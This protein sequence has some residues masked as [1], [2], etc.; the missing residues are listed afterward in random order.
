LGFPDHETYLVEKIVYVLD[1]VNPDD[2]LSVFKIAVFCK[3]IS[4][5]GLDL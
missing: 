4:S 2:L 3:S 1:T 5:I